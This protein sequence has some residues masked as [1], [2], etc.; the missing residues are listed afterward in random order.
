MGY[1]AEYA[2]SS[3]TPD[4]VHKATLLSGLPGLV[5]EALLYQANSFS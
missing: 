2:F 5:R 1:Q 3:E 4:F